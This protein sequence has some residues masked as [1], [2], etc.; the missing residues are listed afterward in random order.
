M[1][2]T[3]LFFMGP[4]CTI[5]LYA[6]GAW[7]DVATRDVLRDPSRGW[8]AP[9]YPASGPQWAL[10]HFERRDANALSD[11]YPVGRKALQQPH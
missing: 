2:D 3:F 7:H 9:T 8:Q 1:R 11:T 10:K 4:S 6:N 5:E